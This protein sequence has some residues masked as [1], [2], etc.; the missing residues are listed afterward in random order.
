MEVSRGDRRELVGI[1]ISDDRDHTRRLQHLRAVPG[2]EVITTMR[3]QRRLRAERRHSIWMAG[4]R[5]LRRETHRVAVHVVVQRGEIREGDRALR[6]QCLRL[7]GGVLRDVGEQFDRGGGVLLRHG[8]RPADA[9][10]AD[11][12]A[13]ASAEQFAVLGDLHRRAP[14]RALEGCARHE[15]GAASDVLTLGARAAKRKHAGVHERRARPAF[16]EHRHAG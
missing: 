16:H 6:L 12:R 9:V 15:Q 3:A 2:L 4:E 8:D 14:C 5:R 7:E 10:P 13:D 11:H 1:G